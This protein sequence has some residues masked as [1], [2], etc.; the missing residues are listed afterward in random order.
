MR[1]NQSSIQHVAFLLCCLLCSVSIAVS[2]SPMI[3]VS[4]VVAP[5]NQLTVNDIDFRHSTTPKWLFTINIGLTGVDTLS[6]RMTVNA[7]F[8]LPNGETHDMAVSFRTVPFLITRTRTVSNLDLGSGAGKIDFEEYNVDN[9]ARRRLEETALPSGEIPAGTY[10]FTVRVT[11]VDGT[12]TSVP[13]PDEFPITLSNPTTVELISPI[14]GDQFA[15]QFPLFQWQYDGPSSRISI[16]EK[17]PG[18]T[19]LEEAASGVPHYSTVTSTTSL[20]YPSSGARVLEP[21]KTYAW[22]VEGLAGATGGTTIARKSVLRS[23][24]VAANNAQSLSSILDELARALPQ[25]QG[26]FDELK[27]QGFTTAGSIRLNDSAIS[28]SE[29]MKIVN[30]LRQD[31]GAVTSVESE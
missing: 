3:T 26:L 21:G 15:T 18:Q 6:V 22:F 14:D 20:Q 10:I 4:H 13:D 24:T 31:P 11:S 1:L 19:S 29:L 30:K 17:L 9:N 25:Y 8:V 28:T 27:A 7:G 5:V 12:I 16:F 2:Q 23:F